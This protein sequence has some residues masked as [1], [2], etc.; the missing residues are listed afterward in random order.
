MIL[1]IQLAGLAH[2]GLGLGSVM[3]PKMLDWKSAF[4]NTPTL[5]KQMFWTYAGY[6]LFI[7]VYFG[8]ISLLLASEMLSGSGLAL[9]TTFLIAIYW[10]ARV[11][12]Q[13]LYFD[14][15]DLPK[16]FIY[17]AGEWILVTLFIAFSIIYTYAFY[18]NYQLWIGSSTLSF[19]G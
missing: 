5:I 7:N 4:T 12:I 3:I 19:F 18:L 10:I 14:A 1:I 6:I 16:T 11:A 9:A 13:F 2:I 15:S 8:V 17:K